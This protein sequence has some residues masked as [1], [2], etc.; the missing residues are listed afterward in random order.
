[1]NKYKLIALDLDGTLNNSKKIITNK[2]KDA[3]IKAQQLGVKV[4]LAS[5][6]PTA[7]LY[8]EAE[9]LNMKEYN[10]MFL[11]YNGAKVVEYTTNKCIYE[12]A[13]SS[14]DT[15]KMLK[16]LKKFSVNVMV[17]SGEYLLVE[18]IDGYKSEYEARLNNLKLKQV[19]D[20]DKYVD[21]QPN[22]I[23]IS[24][25]PEYLALVADEIKEPFGDRLSIYFST[26]F[27]LEVMANNIDKAQALDKIAKHLGIES[28]EVIAFGDGHN[29]IPM[30]EYAGLGVAMANA[31]DDLKAAANEITLSNDDDGIAYIL[32]KKFDQIQ[33]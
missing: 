8:R 2:T 15:H 24:A 28:D 3:L 25:E 22:K 20:L 32:S 12:K 23:L 14:E 9:V 21:F 26:P 30:I 10:G 31:V 6:R 33:F 11:S 13:L 5:G 1:M 7:G 29:D 4:V 17:T 18:D 16:H 27:Y 19:D